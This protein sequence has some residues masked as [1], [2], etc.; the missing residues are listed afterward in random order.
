MMIFFLVFAIVVA[1]VLQKVLLEKSLDAVEGDHWPDCRI[2]D[3]E[4]TFHI[5]VSLRNKGRWFVP[6]LRVR[7]HLP[8]EIL[9]RDEAGGAQEQQHGGRFVDFTTWLRPRQQVKKEIPVCIAKRGRYFTKQLSLYGGDFLGINEQHKYCGRLNEIVVAPRQLSSMQLEDQFG[10]FMGDV[11]VSRF[12]LEDPVLTLGYREYTGRE[13]MKMISW[14]QSARGSGLMV[15]KYDYTLEPSVSV[16]LNVDTDHP[17]RKALLETCYSIARTVCRLLEDR[18][19]KYDFV[20]NAVFAGDLS[21][22]GA[23]GEGLGARHFQSVL[24]RLGRAT[25]AS[26]MTVQRLLEKESQRATSTAGRIFITPAEDPAAARGIAR[27]REVAGGSL[28]V[29]KA[30]EV[31]AW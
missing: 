5:V 14:T 26:G 7:E 30:E 3:P 12:I 4:E 11:S 20:T 31:A 15:K 8:A 9:L 21:D 10:G 28:L 25:Y 24:E 1:L 18:G 23:V 2:V 27:L 22:H 16:V 6:F 19:V 13:P 29:L 17:D